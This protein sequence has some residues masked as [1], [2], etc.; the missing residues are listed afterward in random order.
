MFLFSSLEINIR[1]ELHGWKR[2]RSVPQTE[3]LWCSA[4][5]GVIS[6]AW[7]C[8]PAQNTDT[9][10]GAGQGTPDPCGFQWLWGCVWEKCSS[11]WRCGVWDSLTCQ[12]PFHFLE[13]DFSSKSD[14][15]IGDIVHRRS[16]NH[17]DIKL[18]KRVSRRGSVTAVSLWQVLGNASRCKFHLCPI[19]SV[20]LSE[21]L[22]LFSA[23]G[24][25]FRWDASYMGNHL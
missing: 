6:I 8:I 22:D 7:T 21:K 9:F 10:V 25:D 20:N 2:L 23:I 24:E 18:E 3:P 19:P 4:P 1:F 15:D 11:K 14:R 5:A 12:M 16:K 17:R 13:N